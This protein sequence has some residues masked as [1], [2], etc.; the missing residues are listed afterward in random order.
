M[1][2]VSANHR[3]DRVSMGSV[4]EIDLARVRRFVNRRNNEIPPGA[5]HEIR[6]EMD[7]TPTSVTI[8]ECRPPWRPEYGA[9]WTRHR[10]HGSVTRRPAVSGRSTGKTGTRRSTCTTAFEPTPTVERLLTE[11]DADP[12]CIFWG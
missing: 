6:I 3:C 4:P 12:M 11:I 5:R 10:W 9:E 8:V 7:V 1:S 2:G